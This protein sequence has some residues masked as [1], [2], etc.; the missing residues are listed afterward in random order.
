MWPGLGEVGGVEAGDSFFLISFGDELMLK[1]FGFSNVGL[2]GGLLPE[3]VSGLDPAC[4][5]LELEENLELRLVIQEFRLPAE[6]SLDSL[7]LLEGIGVGFE[8]VLGTGAGAGAE[9]GEAS[10]SDA[11]LL[12]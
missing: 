5:I 7:E 3:V 4:G 8:G 2:L 9:L 11:E 12:D 1:G 6:A 10:F